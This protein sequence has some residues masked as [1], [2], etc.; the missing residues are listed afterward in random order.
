[1]SVD[2][3]VQILKRWQKPIRASEKETASV[4]GVVRT[5]ERRSLI[6]RNVV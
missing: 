4:L 3:C 1:M 6:A 2:A 5:N